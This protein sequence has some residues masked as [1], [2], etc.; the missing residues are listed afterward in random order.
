MNS[1]TK[2]PIRKIYAVSISSLITAIV[3]VLAWIL[4]SYFPTLEIP[5][6]VIG[7]VSIILMVVIPPLMGYAAK[8]NPGDFDYRVPE[9]ATPAPKPIPKPSKPDGKGKAG[10]KK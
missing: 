10:R 3:V 9:R 2:W 5:D 6:E 1:P 7:A 8:N 4:R